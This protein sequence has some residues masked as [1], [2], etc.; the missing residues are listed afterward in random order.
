LVFARD[1]IDNA[2]QVAEARDVVLGAVKLAA[3]EDATPYDATFL[4]LVQKSNLKA[5]TQD[6]GLRG[7]ILGA[8]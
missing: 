8:G 3:E 1:F 4:S 2:C 6:E 7:K 5:S